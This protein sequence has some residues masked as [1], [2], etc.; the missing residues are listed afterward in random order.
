METFGYL[1]FPGLLTDRIQE[2]D[3]AFEQM[4]TDHGGGSHEGRKRLAVAPFLNHHPYLCSL[5]D[6][7]RIAGIAESL[8]GP[9]YQYWNSDGNYYVGD[10][11][12]HSD[13]AW[14]EP[15]RFYKIALYLDPLTR[16]SG[17]LRV[18][19]GSHRYGDAY[20]E[21]LQA[22]IRTSEQIWGVHGSQVPAVA[23]ETNPGDLVMFNHSTKH[24][25]WG[26]S[27]K[28]RMFTIVFTNLHT[29]EGVT[30]FQEVVRSHRYTKQEVFGGSDGPLLR[31]APPERLRHLAQL[32]EHIPDTLS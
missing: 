30:H 2:I 10:T 28:R 31:G 18:I 20:A 23:L 1:S 24:S 16:D 7:E 14:P 5:L 25:A 27:Q 17:A 9:D 15:I 8:L 32:L 19:P 21:A 6:D 11:P 13:T 12:W 26:G 4:I 29:G 22:N 3:A